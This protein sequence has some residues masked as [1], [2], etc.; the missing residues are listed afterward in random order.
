MENILLIIIIG[1]SGIGLG[2][3]IHLMFTKKGINSAENR[4]KEILEDANKEATRIKKEGKLEVKDEI[5][6]VRVKFEDSTKERKKEVLKQEQWLEQK[7]INLDRRIDLIE[8]KEEDVN[9]DREKIIVLKEQVES[10][11]ERVKHIIKEE[12]V[13]LQRIA[14]LSRE[15]A[16]KRLLES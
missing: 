8:K 7:K 12:E 5:N 10:E 9:A 11:G 6:R 15:E 4:A 14:G 1:I 13:A 2:V 16:Y 3:L